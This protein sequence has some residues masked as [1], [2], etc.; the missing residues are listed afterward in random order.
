VP[1]INEKMYPS[2]NQ[3]ISESQDFSPDKMANFRLKYADK[4]S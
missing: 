4:K 3:F 1:E 2:N